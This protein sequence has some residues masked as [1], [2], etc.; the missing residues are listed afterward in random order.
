MIP[1]HIEAAGLA[2]T[3]PLEQEPPGRPTDALVKIVERAGRPRRDQPAGQ[4]RTR[5]RRTGLAEEKAHDTARARPE[6]QPATGG[7]VE[8]PRRAA[9]LGDSRGKASAAQPLLEDPE[10]LPRPADADDDQ[11]S[12]V[13]A[14]TIEADT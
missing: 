9:D 4:R 2:L 13:E 11:F 7:E 12:R 6:S 3:V 14:E 1:L 10:R 5:L 8:F